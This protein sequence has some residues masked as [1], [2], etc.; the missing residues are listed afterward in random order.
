MVLAAALEPQRRGTVMDCLSL[1]L[2]MTHVHFTLA[3]H[4]RS[5]SVGFL[6][7]EA[8]VS[9][10]CPRALQQRSEGAPFSFWIEFPPRAVFNLS[11]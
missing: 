1:S 2:L 5:P 7:Q 9:A 10:K 8:R 4:T 6:K 11:L 3:N